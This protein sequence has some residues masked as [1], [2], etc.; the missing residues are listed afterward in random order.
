VF[1][2]SRKRKRRQ[3]CQ[4]LDRQHAPWEENAHARIIRAEKPARER[5]E[6]K[7]K[8][9]FDY[10][11]L[12]RSGCRENTR[13]PEKPHGAKNPGGI[14]VAKA[15][16]GNGNTRGTGTR[17]SFGWQKSVGRIAR[18]GHREVASLRGENPG[19]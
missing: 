14:Q 2:P 5:N 4:R 13:S 16:K 19:R 18:L 15:A 6:A 9:A 17:Q 1:H 10:D 3:R 8:G 7:A 12:K 11:P